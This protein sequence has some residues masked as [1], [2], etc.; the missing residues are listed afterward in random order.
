MKQAVLTGPRQFTLSEAAMPSLDEDEVLVRV[1]ACGVC[2]SE[3]NA[4][5]GAEGAARMLGHEVAGEV[6]ATG[7][8]AEGLNIG[9][10]VTGLF[11]QGLSDYAVTKSDRVALV[12]KEIRLEHA[13]GEPLACAVSATQRTRVD[14]GDRVA[15][16][17]LGFM[18]L[19]MLQLI[20]LKGP[21]VL[22]GIDVRDDALAA[23]RRLGVDVA[24]RP[25]EVEGSDRIVLPIQ[26][27]RRR[28]YDVVVEATGTQ[29]G[30]TLAGELV[31]EHGVLSILGYH[32]GGP[33][34]VNMQLWNYKA[35]D[36]LNAHERRVGYRMECMKR[37]LALAAAG[38][39]ELASLATHQ[40]RLHQVN[41]AFTALESKPKGFIK[42]VVVP[43]AG[44]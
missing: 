18:G 23:A 7:R 21:A 44:T 40:F 35:L 2:A 1:H 25:D 43:D 20:W 17:G 36:V 38:R 16:I 12:P 30:L 14:L 37:G 6:V 42:S 24:I 3:L 9:D 33:R 34:E 29:P 13:F 4:W 27:G 26:P 15:I 31:R 19:L 32:Q 22:V 39:I 41:E 5:Q 10:R 28:G 8:R 11:G